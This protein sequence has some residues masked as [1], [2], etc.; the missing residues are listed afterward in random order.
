VQVHSRRAQ[1]IW[2]LIPAL[3]LY[4]QLLAAQ[5]GESQPAAQGTVATDPAA[6]PLQPSGSAAGPQAQP[7]QQ[8]VP[9]ERQPPPQQPLGA[10]TAEQVRI[11]GGV[12]SRP[13]GNAIAPTRQHQSRM[14]VIKVGAVVA[15][16]AAVG[17]VVG[18]SRATPSVPPHNGTASTK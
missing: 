16:A 3:L 4:S 9:P 11:A 10:A 17:A 1:V 14:L 18:L 2:L 13:A 8:M 7:R 6:S 12:A 15:G 5:Q